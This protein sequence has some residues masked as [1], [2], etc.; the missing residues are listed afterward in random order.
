MRQFASAGSGA[1]RP[2]QGQS[3]ASVAIKSL[4]RLLSCSTLGPEPWAL[5]YM[6]IA[7][8]VILTRTPRIPVTGLGGPVALESAP[9]DA[10]PVAQLDRAAP[11]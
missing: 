6:G 5:E 9:I 10:V 2:A 4:K 3:E 11:S 1:E 8:H 7:R